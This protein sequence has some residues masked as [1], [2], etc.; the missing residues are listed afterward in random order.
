MSDETGETFKGG[1][2]F[3]MGGLAL[4]LGLYNVMR[5]MEVRGRGHAINVA[6]YALLLGLEA[7]N[8][9]HHWGRT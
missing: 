3:L 1:I 8:T 6:A 2:H 4:A 9:K 7:K 5:F